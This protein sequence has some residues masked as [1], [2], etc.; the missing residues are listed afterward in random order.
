MN[1][2]GINQYMKCSQSCLVLAL[3]LLDRLQD[4]KPLFVVTEKNIHKLMMT[5]AVV[6]AKSHED[7]IY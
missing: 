3:I 6:A 5:A 4:E 2:L 1:D 7:T